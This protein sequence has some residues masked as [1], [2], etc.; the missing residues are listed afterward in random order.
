[1][2]QLLGWVCAAVVGGLTAMAASVS[3]QTPPAPR[4]PTNPAVD[5]L[6]TPVAP[7]RIIDTRGAGGGPI[8]AGATRSFAVSGDT[9]FTPQGGNA[10]GCGIPLGA[11]AA[12]I[13]YVA[14]GP[15]GPGDLRV[16]AFGTPIPTAS[17]INYS[18]IAGLNI[19][20]GV[21]TPL[22]TAG[23]PHITVQADVSATDLVADVVGYYNEVSCQAGTVKVLGACYETALRPDAQFEVASDTCRAAGGRLVPGMELRSLRGQFPLILATDGEW[24]ADFRSNDAAT[25]FFGAIVKNSGVIEYFLTGGASTFPYRCVFRPLP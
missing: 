13:N 18:N 15:V 16:T 23:A 5:L 7:C 6:F 21:A 10:T 1:M 17:I 22:G 11:P 8:A 12:I 20:N 14:V 3:A 24:A 25:F 2:K 4:L 19:A 9:G